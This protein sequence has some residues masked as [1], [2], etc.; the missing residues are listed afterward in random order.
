MAI[1]NNGEP[2]TAN[3]LFHG[4]LTVMS[5]L[6]GDGSSQIEI[7]RKTYSDI[8]AKQSRASLVSYE[9]IELVRGILSNIKKELDSGFVGS[10]QKHIAGGVIADF[11]QL[12]KSILNDPGDAAK[13]VAAVLTAAA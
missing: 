7:L 5:N 11:I 9:L 8:L 10:L 12:A 4:T 6:Y 2:S 1:P 3:E 13:N